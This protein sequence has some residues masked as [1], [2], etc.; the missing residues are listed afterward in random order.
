M[1]NKYI[2][3]D[4]TLTNYE[5]HKKSIRDKD[6]DVSKNID[7]DMA[8]EEAAYAA[9]KNARTKLA[10]ERAQA[11][12]KKKNALMTEELIAQDASKGEVAEWIKEGEAELEASSKKIAANKALVEKRKAAKLDR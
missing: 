12:S 1:E 6:G 11:I 2:I 5:E 7:Q 4:G 10:Q 8:A 3:K 9:K